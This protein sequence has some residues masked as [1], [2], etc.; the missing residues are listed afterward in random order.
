MTVPENS[1]ITFTCQVDANPL[2]ELQWLLNNQRLTS[3]NARG[4]NVTGRQLMITMASRLHVGQI[5]CVATNTE[6][7]ISS[8][9]TLTILCK[10]NILKYS[11]Y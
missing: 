3:D 4:V 5:A 2:A 7:T 11:N 10:G 9:A 1:S 8:V 6:G